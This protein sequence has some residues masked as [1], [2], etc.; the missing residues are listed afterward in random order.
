MALRSFRED[1]RRARLE[2]LSAPV[3]KK[4]VKPEVKN[5]TLDLKAKPTVKKVEK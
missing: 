1:P 4:E 5:E 3:I 2:A